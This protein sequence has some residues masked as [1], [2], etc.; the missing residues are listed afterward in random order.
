MYY[1]AK[2]EV[3]GDGYM[4]SFPDVPE[5]LTQGDTIQKAMEMASDALLT[6]MDFYLEDGRK[7]KPPTPVFKDDGDYY[8]IYISD[9]IVNAIGFEAV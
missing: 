6:S 8:P 2:I 5:A 7:L 4:V 3:D 9:K 1:L